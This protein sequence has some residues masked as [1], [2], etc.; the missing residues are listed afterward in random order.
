MRKIVEMCLWVQWVNVKN[1]AEIRFCPKQYITR[2]KL[3]AFVGIFFES[4][5]EKCVKKNSTRNKS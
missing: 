5:K 4:C 1:F 2:V 3:L